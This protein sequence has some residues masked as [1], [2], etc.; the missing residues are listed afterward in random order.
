MTSSPG[1][2]TSAP[3]YWQPDGTGTRPAQ[4]GKRQR[5]ALDLLAGGKGRTHS[6]TA[7]AQPWPARATLALALEIL[8]PGPCSGTLT[9]ASWPSSGKAV[10]VRLMMEQ[11]Q[12]VGSVRLPGL[13]GTGQALSSPRSDN[14]PPG[15]PPRTATM[16][17]TAMTAQQRDMVD[18]ILRNAP[19][20]LGRGTPPPSAPSSSRCSPPS[21]CR[22][23]VPRGRPVDLGG[24]PRCSSSTNRP[25]PSRAGT[26]FPTSTAAAFALGSAAGSAGLVVRPGPQEPACA[27]RLSR[28]PASHP[29]NPYP[30]ALQDVQRPP[31]TTWPSSS[32]SPPASPHVFPDIRPPLLDE[33]DGRPQP[34][35]P[36]SSRTTP[37]TRLPPDQR[38]QAP[39]ETSGKRGTRSWRHRRRH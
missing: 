21:P 35:P 36:G 31:P 9:T 15:H 1:S 39:G 22:P 20:D 10:L 29:S 13:R 32:T 5:A 33:G 25:A 2:I 30:A 6:S 38:H 26:I 12:P 3:G 14:G 11:R 4:P 27:R 28:L 23:D 7:A 24:N 17:G 8:T 18:Q 16:N 34:R 37:P 19:F